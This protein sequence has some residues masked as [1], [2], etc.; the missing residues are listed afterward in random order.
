M[1]LAIKLASREATADEYSRPC[2]YSIH[3]ATVN[4]ATPPPLIREPSER[5][6]ERDDDDFPSRLWQR[7]TSPVTTGPALDTG[8]VTGRPISNQ[9]LEVRLLTALL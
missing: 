8:L 6:T 1:I 4:N 5:D 3:T 7:G 9:S 2:S